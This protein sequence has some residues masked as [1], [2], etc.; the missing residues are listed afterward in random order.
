M[1]DNN[2]ENNIKHHTLCIDLVRKH[3]YDVD[4]LNDYYLYTRKIVAKD[5]NMGFSIR[6]VRSMQ[7]VKIVRVSLLKR[8]N[9][10]KP[11]LYD[12]N[13]DGCQFIRN[14]ARN[15]VANLFYQFLKEFSNINHACPY[16]HDVLIDKLTILNGTVKLPFPLGEYALDTQWV[17]NNRM[18]LRVNGSCI[19]W[20]E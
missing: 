17:I 16:D 10:W 7:Q 14:P 15:P 13:V 19:Y 8:A 11:F 3:D 2:N 5:S 6:G 12:I 20:K 18:L 1:T 9:G 4:R